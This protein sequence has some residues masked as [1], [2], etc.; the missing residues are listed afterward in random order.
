MI[1]RHCVP[2][3][4]QPGNDEQMWEIDPRKIDRADEPQVYFAWVQFSSLGMIN[5]Q[6]SSHSYVQIY[7]LCE[8]YA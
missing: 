7:R 2:S 3:F 5:T 4:H 6:F 1:R 8:S